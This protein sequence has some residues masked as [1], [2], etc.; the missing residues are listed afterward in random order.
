MQEFDIL[1]KM[2]HPHILKVIECF[3]D[4]KY[5]YIVTELIKGGELFTQL[6]KQ[7]SFSE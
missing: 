3:D 4:S 1:S 5:V 2:D 6:L 7:K